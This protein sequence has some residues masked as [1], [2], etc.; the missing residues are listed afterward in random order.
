M[1]I[2]GHSMVPALNPNE[3]VFVGDGTA[4]S[5]VPRRGEIVAA[6]PASMGGKVLVKRVVGL[7]R[8]RV[9]A[10]ERAWQLDDGEFFLAGDQPE[11]SVDSRIFGPVR[12]EELLGPL[13]WR[14]WPWKLLAASSHKEGGPWG[15]CWPVGM[16][17]RIAM[18]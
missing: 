3:L 15:R 9:R 2:H 17:V 13:R 18:R 11:Q 16:W 5:W 4:S 14:L 7:P 12:Q 10:G 6:R 1:R 8:E